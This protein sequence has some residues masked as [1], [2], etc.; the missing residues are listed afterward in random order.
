[1]TKW[2]KKLTE[3]L[4]AKSKANKPKGEGWFTFEQYKA[5]QKCGYYTA[6][7]RMKQAI[8]QGEIEIYKGSE[9][10]ES[11]L[12]CRQIWYRKIIVAI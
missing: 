6:R 3:S 4:G 10:K 11:G 12:L 8:I 9:Y 1:M 7:K 5:D 2:Y